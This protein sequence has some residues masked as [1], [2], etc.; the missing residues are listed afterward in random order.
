MEIITSVDCNEGEKCAAMSVLLD[1]V[2]LIRESFETLLFAT[3]P[4]TS[5][6]FVLILSIRL[7]GAIAF[8]PLELLGP[9]R[10][11]PLRSAIACSSLSSK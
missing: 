9:E 10:S 5:G 4:K 7:T 3:L 8:A 6:K 11:L 1:V 2:D